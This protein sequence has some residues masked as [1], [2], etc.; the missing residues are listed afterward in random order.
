[1]RGRGGSWV[2]NIHMS[3]C[4]YACMH[5]CM[6]AVACS[7]CVCVCLCV[8]AGES[9]YHIAYVSTLHAPS[10]ASTCGG[11]ATRATWQ[12]SSASWST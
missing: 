2:G 3:V 1:V 5:A 11:Q 10:H 4:L 8:W 6:Y 9:V 7:V 12:R